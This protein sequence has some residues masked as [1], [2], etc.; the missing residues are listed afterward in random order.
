MQKKYYAIFLPCLFAG[1]ALM[2]DNTLT[3][4]EN[5]V[6][7]NW[8]EGAWSP[9][10][11]DESNPDNII[12]TS[13][14]GV[15]GASVNLSGT[16]SGGYALTVNGASALNI[17]A[18]GV[19]NI[20][21]DTSSGSVAKTSSISG[22]STVTV[23]GEGAQL[24]VAT[25]QNKNELFS[26]GSNSTLEVKNG[27]TLTISKGGRLENSDTSGKFIADGANLTLS[28]WN[29]RNVSIKNS[30]ATS[31]G[32]GNMFMMHNTNNYVV[33]DN[34]VVS[35][36]NA[37]GT[38]DTLFFLVGNQ[39][40]IKID[41]GSVVNGTNYNFDDP[42]EVSVS[43]ITGSSSQ[44]GWWS[45]T[46][47][48]HVNSIE[49]T[50]GSKF[51][52]QYFRWGG[53]ASGK[54]STDGLFKL[55]VKG[56]YNEETGTTRTSELVVRSFEVGQGALIADSNLKYQMLFEGYQKSQFQNISLA[57]SRGMQSG[58]VLLKTSGLE[59]EFVVT[60]NLELHGYRVSS[61][62][63][64]EALTSTLKTTFEITGGTS[65]Q[66]SGATYI[67][68][69]DAN[70]GTELLSIAGTNNGKAFVSTSDVKFLALGNI[71]VRGSS[72][73]GS[74]QVSTLKIEGANTVAASNGT[75]RW[76]VWQGTDTNAGG[77]SQII[78]NSSSGVGGAALLGGTWYMGNVNS[79]GG[80]NYAEIKG[81]ADAQNLVGFYAIEMRNSTSADSTLV[82]RVVV[83]GYTNLT[84]GNATNN[85]IVGNGDY[86]F[87][88]KV[89][90]NESAGGLSELVIRGEGNSLRM[91]QM[92]AGNEASTG[93]VGRIVLEGGSNV[94]EAVANLNISGGVGTSRTNVVGGELVLKAQNDTLSGVV[95]DRVYFTGVLTLDFSQFKGI[96]GETYSFKILESRQGWGNPDNKTSDIGLLLEGANSDE[97]SNQLV[98]MIKLG[99]DDQ[100]WLSQD[101]NSIILNYVTYVPE[102]ST[103]AAIF[104]AL[105]LAF[106]AYRRRK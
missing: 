48:E 92:L 88:P 11:P 7:V 25:D 69:N 76:N 71:N 5:D 6:E 67:G 54:N 89:G 35:G 21:A 33:I 64:P 63:N 50:G 24:N 19:L 73:S 39:A 78:M 47:A 51:S 30:T 8:A 18:G 99:A 72:V 28:F 75:G 15:T 41:N 84:G 23:A 16:Q 43:A 96:E 74:T 55:V 85:P 98:N 3:L 91:W 38:W 13:A 27:G 2:A 57:S 94:V 59:N 17:G 22:T 87:R 104:G 36:K 93:G 81:T 26:I 32:T 45:Q 42:S 31:N 20:T 10:L 97:D 40:D 61:S 86:T 14:D 80:L 60:N 95:S 56:D 68:D 101:G 53:D 46:S 44:I 102:P 4:T 66:V 49:V 1:A 77:T 58:E 100:W 9:A 105:A 103:Y 37:N 83:N 62:Q 65:L 34:S 106:A 52:S 90:T 70:A 82:N 29:A 12:I 79:T